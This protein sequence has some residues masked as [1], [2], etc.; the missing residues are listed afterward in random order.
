MGRKKTNF[1]INLPTSWNDVSLLK[2]MELEEI[3]KKG[4]G[5]IN[6]LEIVSCLSGIEKAELQ[7]YP[8]EVINVIFE[9]LAF[10]RDEQIDNVPQAY[11]TDDNG[12]EYFINTEEKLKM[13]EFVDAQMAMQDDEHKDYPLLL[14]ILCR[15]EGERYDDDFIA[16]TL[17]S[18]I[19][20]F[21]NAS[22]NKVFPIVNFILASAIASSTTINRFT[23]NL[24]DI[25]EQSLMRLNNIEKGGI[26][27]R[28]YLNYRTKKLLK[29]LRCLKCI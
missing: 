23:D 15:K 28:L 14:A 4:E 29:S 11:F 17:P 20:M 13:G 16:N 5:K 22:I 10:L 7:Q 18:R 24:I 6:T 21:Q 8:S 3:Y 25:T 19:T 9:H 2:Y 26:G 12:E 27:R 1:K